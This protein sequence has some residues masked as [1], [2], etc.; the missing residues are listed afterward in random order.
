MITFQFINALLRVFHTL[1][2]KV[3][4]EGSVVNSIYASSPYRRTI[5][6]WSINR[7]FYIG[8]D[9]T[10]RLYFYVKLD[11][12]GRRPDG[13]FNEIIHEYRTY[14]FH[15]AIKKAYLFMENEKEVLEFK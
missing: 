11:T 8:R 9:Y 4:L 15:K 3:L 10:D 14:D 12:F 7:S 5:N 2:L 13:E 6:G 1:G